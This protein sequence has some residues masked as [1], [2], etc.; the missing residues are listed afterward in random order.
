MLEQLF[1]S[2]TRVKIL[3][4]FFANPEEDYFVREIT[5]RI[6]EQINSVRRE[7]SN[8]EKIGILTSEEKSRKK[9]Y[10]VDQTFIL[11]SELRG[12][13]LK[14]RMTLEKRMIIKSKKQGPFLIWLYV[15]IL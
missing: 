13:F 12:L 2:R 15:D 11:Y 10:S 1:G 7:L 5:R 8:L 9:Y 3:R 4:L 6:G 14:S